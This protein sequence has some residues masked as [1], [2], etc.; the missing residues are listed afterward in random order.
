MFKFE[1]F[2]SIL[3]IIL[4]A[5]RIGL[6]EALCKNT[7]IMADFDELVIQKHMGAVELCRVI[8]EKAARLIVAVLSV[9]KG[10][11]SFE[12]V[13]SPEFYQFGSVCCS[14]PLDADGCYETALVGATGDLIYIEELGYEEVRRFK[15]A[16]DLFEEIKRLYATASYLK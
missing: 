15:T 7:S 16:D 5:W 3:F 1:F 10:C 2:Y 8:G 12:I 6:F 9:S 14:V 4:F 13:F 11:N